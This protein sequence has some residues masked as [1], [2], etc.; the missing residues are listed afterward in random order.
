MDELGWVERQRAY[1]ALREVLHALRDRLSVGEAVALA[2]QLPLL[3]RGVYYEGW[4]PAGKPVKH[5][6]DAFLAHLC[7]ALR[8]LGPGGAEAVTRAV[9]RVLGRHVSHGGT[10]HVRRTLPADFRALWASRP[11]GEQP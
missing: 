6:R 5:H 2:A 7:D 3:V 9:F 4:H 1:H 11:E 8:G 10:E